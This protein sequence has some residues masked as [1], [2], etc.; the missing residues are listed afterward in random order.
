MDQNK[1]SKPGI[2]T[3]TLLGGVL[4]GLLSSIPIISAF[5]II[6]CLWVLL[7]GFV[8]AMLYQ[9]DGG[10]LD[11]SQGAF[12]GFIAGL[13]GTVIITAFSTLLFSFQSQSMGAQ[14]KELVEN[15]NMQ[16]PGG[17]MDML[18]KM[19]Q[20]IGIYIAFTALTW[21][22]LNSIFATLGGL[23]GSAILKSRNPG[24]KKTGYPSHS[25]MTPPPEFEID[26][27]EDEEN[28]DENIDK[29]D[30]S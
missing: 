27:D 11:A 17:S 29:E 5:N 18:F 26:R 10:Y 9:K 12:L 6:C 22:I 25:T 21:F 7:G 15:L 8:A 14:W 23:I 3:P 19:Q 24:Q 4:L 1:N 13:W 2:L 28:N 30:K 20:N 16:M